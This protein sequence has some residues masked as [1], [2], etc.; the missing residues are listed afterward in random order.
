M[1]TLRLAERILTAL[2][3]SHVGKYGAAQLS[4]FQPDAQLSQI[5]RKRLDVRIVIFGIGAQ[6]I[7]GQFARRPRFIKWM[8]EQVVVMN[9]FFEQRQKCL[10]FHNF[11]HLIYPD[12]S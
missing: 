6:I 9:A 2:L 10:R 4:F 12:N 1:R 5:A 8:T 3:I 11:S 7:A